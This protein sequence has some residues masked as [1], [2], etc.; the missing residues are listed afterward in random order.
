MTPS[1][2]EL[3][4]GRFAICRLDP[5]AALP[6]DLGQGSLFSVTR[7]EN[8]LSVVCRESGV[9]PGEVEGGWRCLRVAGP[10]EFTQVGILAALTQPLADAGVSI[11]AV[12]TFDTDYL[13]VKEEQI[14]TA[15]AALRAAGHKV[16]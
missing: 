1:N 7:T 6:A 10:L 5:E 9:L 11:F 2:L 8:E 14:D 15:I 16:S 3:L 4:S 12:S 13:L